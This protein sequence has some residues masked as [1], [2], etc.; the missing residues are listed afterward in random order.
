MDN[1]T[2]Q[3]V[4][5]KAAQTIENKTI[6]SPVFTGALSMEGFTSSGSATIGDAAADSL[7]VNAAATFAAS[8]TFSNTLILS[9]GATVTGD[10]TL[11]DHL[12]MVDDKSIKLG[13]DD[14]FVISYT[15][16]TD[17]VTITTSASQLLLFAPV[18]HCRMAVVISIL[19]QNTDT[20][21]YHGGDGSAR[22]TT[23]NTGISIEVL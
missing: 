12:D 9:Q 6:V 11:N 15:N 1:T 13:T 19:K 7:T 2:D 3:L 14:D 16:A 8:T 21:I 10:V 17:L 4:T 5:L 22:I 23:T 20:G 18:S